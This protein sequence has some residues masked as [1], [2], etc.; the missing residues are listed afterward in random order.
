[1][2]VIRD[3]MKINDLIKCQNDLI[4][5]SLLPLVCSDYVLMD[6]PYYSN[7]GDALIWKGTEQLLSVVSYKCL[8]RCSFRTFEYQP[9]PKDVVIIM[10]GGGNWGDLYVQHNTFRKRILELYPNNRVVI[11]PQTVYYE[12][13]RN[14]R[15]DAA[16]FRRH[17]HLTI[18]A[19]DN[20]SYRFLKFFRFSSDVRMMPDMAFCLD[21][22]W[23]K[24][25]S[26]PTSEKKLF[27]KRTDKELATTKCFNEEEVLG[28][29]D[30]GDWP[31][32]GQTDPMLNHLDALIESKQFVE[33]NEYAVRSY[34]PERIRAGVEFIGQYS[35]VYSNRLH[36]A[37]LALLL[38]KK[39]VIIDNS[40]GK[41]SQYYNTWLKDVDSVSLLSSSRKY[42]WRRLL[43]FLYHCAL[44][45]IKD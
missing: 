43:R 15:R 44:S 11:L 34:L 37:I 25:L 42:D 23:L 19:R 27:F 1:M 13:A 39:V 18:F 26:W 24:S 16:S 21:I 20:Y 29:Y 2:F 3:K 4:R 30:V 6:L 38:G 36:G 14:A 40:Y 17:K 31:L 35:E 10:M 28:K 9:F 22:E 33:A 12:G 8:Y 5:E 41:N 32:Y 7:I 45:Y